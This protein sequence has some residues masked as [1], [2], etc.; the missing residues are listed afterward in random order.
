MFHGVPRAGH[1]TI[2]S[3]VRHA[4]A[5]LLGEVLHQYEVGQPAGVGGRV[6]DHPS[7]DQALPVGGLNVYDILRHENMLVMQ[8]ALGAIQGRL[9]R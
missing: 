4:V 9:V 5:Q 8:E 6:P 1:G 7:H 2:R 3:S